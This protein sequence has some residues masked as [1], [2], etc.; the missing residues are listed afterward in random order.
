MIVVGKSR[1]DV[2][3]Q[4]RIYCSESLRCGI[5]PAFRGL[6]Q[7]FRVE[8]SVTKAVAYEHRRQTQGEH[9]DKDNQ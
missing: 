7:A 9:Q 8:Y 3:S 4:D 2:F 5:D 6:D 1:V